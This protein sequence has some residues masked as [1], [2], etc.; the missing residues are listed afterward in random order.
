MIKYIILSLA[1]LLLGVGIGYKVRSS[2][3][4]Q[5]VEKIKQ[6]TKTIT[7]AGE[8]I[9]KTEEKVV[10]KPS[11]GTVKKY[12]LGVSTKLFNGSPN[13]DLV[14]GSYKLFDPIWID[15]GYQPKTNSYILGISL[16]F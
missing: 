7:A 3:T 6:V 2:P 10:F 16:E 5:V 4:V 13:V 15:A 11:G 8:T 12:K 9:F 14:Q 1:F